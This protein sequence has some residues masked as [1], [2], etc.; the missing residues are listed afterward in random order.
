M[1]PAAENVGGESLQNLLPR[2]KGFGWRNK[3]ILIGA[4][5]EKWVGMFGRLSMYGCTPTWGARRGRILWQKPPI[6]AA[7]TA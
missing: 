3:P 7:K 5:R 6:L 4:F 1:L 2:A